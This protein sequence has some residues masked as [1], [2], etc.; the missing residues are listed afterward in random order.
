MCVC[1]FRVESEE[2]LIE[3]VGGT[4]PSQCAGMERVMGW[5][6]LSFSARSPV[7]GTG[8]SL[9]VLGVIPNEHKGTFHE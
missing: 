3:L 4:P 5:Q 6:N 8:L 9:F 1:P 2:I 7:P